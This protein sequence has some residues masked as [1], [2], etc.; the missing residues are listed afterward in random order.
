MELQ[1]RSMYRLGLSLCSQSPINV[2]EDSGVERLSAQFWLN[3]YKTKGS[4]TGRHSF[5]SLFY[6]GPCILPQPIILPH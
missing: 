2:W 1:Q 5:S 6:C 3:C 4:S